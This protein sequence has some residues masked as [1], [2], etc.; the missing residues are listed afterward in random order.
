[1]KGFKDADVKALQQSDV[2]KLVRIRKMRLCLDYGDSTDQP[3]PDSGG[4]EA[5]IGGTSV[6]AELAD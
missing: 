3:K 5:L 1:M 6:V 2:Q 4:L